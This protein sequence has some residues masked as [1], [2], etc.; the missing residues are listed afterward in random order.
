MR[1]QY[2]NSSIIFL[3]YAFHALLSRSR[4]RD[5][6][7]TRSRRITRRRQVGFA[8]V[9]QCHARRRQRRLPAHGRVV[10]FFLACTLWRRATSVGFCALGFTMIYSL[11]ALIMDCLYAISRWAPAFHCRRAISACHYGQHIEH[12]AAWSPPAVGSLLHYLLDSTSAAW[13]RSKKHQF[14]PLMAASPPLRGA[15]CSAGTVAS[16]KCARG[17]KA[18]AP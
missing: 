5:T 8:H 6:G 12:S 18:T 1:S 2:F 14:Q 17:G 16:S 7:H 13:P 9:A 15:A 11:D 4:A 10:L 3:Q